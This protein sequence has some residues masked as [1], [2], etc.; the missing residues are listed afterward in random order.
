[1]KVAP[2]SQIGLSEFDIGEILLFTQRF[3]EIDL[4]ILFGSR[5][6][7]THKKGSDVDLVISGVAVSYAI[8]NELSYLL[9]EESVLPYYFDILY[10]ADISSVAL[11]AH[12]K[13]YGVVLN[14]STTNI[15]G[16]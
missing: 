7:G 8:V 13:E 1:M 11:L 15:K 16:N 9:N 12:I 10:F 4:V 2:I 3:A 6:K 5:A 14:K